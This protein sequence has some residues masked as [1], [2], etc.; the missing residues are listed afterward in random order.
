M[1]SICYVVHGASY[2]LFSQARSFGWALVWIA[3]SRAAVAVSS[4]LN[5][6]QLLRH[7]QNDY[8]GR[9][10]STIETWTWMTMIVSMGV[11]GAVADHVSPRT[12]GAWSGLLSST[13]AIFWG[14]AN[15]AGRLP[16]PAVAGVEPEE[17]EVHRDSGV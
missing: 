1:V 7:V 14:W 17:I 4:V 11:T 5:T 8:R 13:T 6:S 10:F 15:W 9:V 2:I 3:M 12:I 16:E